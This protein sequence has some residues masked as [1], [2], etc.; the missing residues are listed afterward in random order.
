MAINSHYT[1][2]A[3]GLGFS[4]ENM[5]PSA[6]AAQDFYRFAAGRWLDQIIIPDTEGQINGFKRLYFLINQQILALLF[7]LSFC[8]CTR[9]K[10]AWNSKLAISLPPSWI[11]I[12]SMHWA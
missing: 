6:D 10:A 1:D 12:G 7:H 3:N 11:H 9:E 8:A 5:D 2:R 4:V